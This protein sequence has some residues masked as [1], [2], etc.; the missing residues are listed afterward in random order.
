[1]TVEFDLSGEQYMALNGGP[2]FK[3]NEAIS[4]CDRGARR[5]KRSTAT[6]TR[7]SPGGGAEQ[8]CGWLRDRFGLS[9]QI[10]P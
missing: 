8:M 6:G 7:C 4:I 10:L 3:F 2:H 5:R 1:M 9:W